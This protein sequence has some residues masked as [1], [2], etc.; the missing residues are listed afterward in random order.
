MGS[1]SLPVRK[2]GHDSM[3]LELRRPVLAD[4]TVA[5][6]SQGTAKMEATGPALADA[7]AVSGPE[8][9]HEAPENAIGAA[10]T[11]VTSPDPA[12]T[13]AVSGHEQAIGA[14]MRT[15]LSEA[16][17]QPEYAASEEQSQAPLWGASDDWA[18]LRP[19]LQSYLHEDSAPLPAD[20]TVVPAAYFRDAEF[21]IPNPTADFVLVS[22]GM[23][24]TL[25]E[26]A[27]GGCHFMPLIAL[28]QGRGWLKHSVGQSRW[29]DM[30]CAVEG[31]CAEAVVV[32]W[33]RDG[34]DC[35]FHSLLIALHCKGVLLRR[36]LCF[37]DL[38]AEEEATDVMQPDPSDAMLQKLRAG[39]SRAEFEDLL[40]P[41]RLFEGLRSK[42]EVYDTVK[43]N[44]SD[45]WSDTRT[46]RQLAA[47]E[48]PDL[49]LCAATPIAEAIH[50]LARAR[51]VQAD[52]LM[53]C[54]DSNI[55]FLEQAGTV[56]CH[57]V[58][59]KH[60]ISPGSAVIIGSASSTRKSAL[61]KLTDEW[62]C[63]VPH[64]GEEFR[65]RSILTTDSTTKGIRNCL[66][67][68]GRCGVSSDEAANTFET[69]MSDRDAGLHFISMTKLNTWTQSEYD[70]PTTG[71]GSFS[72][73]Q[74]QFL[75]KAAGQTEVVEQIIFPKVHGFQKR[76]KQIWVSGEL[77]TQDH[78]VFAASDSL[79]HD[80]H[81]FMH[82]MC[83][84]QPPVT[85]CLDG[86]ALSMYEAAKQAIADFLSENKLPQVFKT[87]LM[88][89]HSDANETEI[90]RRLRMS[91]DE[92]SVALHKWISQARTHF[93]SY[94][95]AA[96]KQQEPASATKQAETPSSLLIASPEDEEKPLNSEDIF[97]KNLISRVPNNTWFTSADVRGW[98]RN[99]RGDAFR[100]DLRAKI[101]KAFAHL[102]QHGLLQ[103]ASD[104]ATGARHTQRAA[105]RA[106]TKKVT[107]K[108][109][110]TVRKRTVDEIR[111]EEAA[112]VKAAPVCD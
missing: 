17:Q 71:H 1:T 99:R 88:F 9:A 58:R 74:Y 57:N 21:L 42:Q 97:M 2:A 111:G 80:W 103:K 46:H 66:K 69:K 6:A 35:Y 63:D 89:Y 109:G 31:R 44:L 43:G 52:A 41:D 112:A 12:D 107:G 82:R 64:A 10:R 75:L 22:G 19:V 26:H 91:L 29:K 72:L 73:S 96:C 15:C 61:I 76:L 49:R 100:K 106:A 81:S 7:S 38:F 39:L 36:G 90:M 50:A 65:D 13:L 93:A 110:L 14:H 34:G 45:I 87:K 28:D 92:F 56:L 54:V 62:L 37:E 25:H 20:V 77:Q 98:L 4:E 32:D 16:R 108:G 51:G 95:F 47:E 67:E 40:F 18:L 48:D 5:A 60:F 94:R 53:A 84:A 27:T 78:Q 104:K 86:R 68:F 3:T 8:K 70:G 23:D 33:V 101:E 30:V 105:K 83:V 59:A 55:G 11:E 79:L 24:N 102:L 85:V